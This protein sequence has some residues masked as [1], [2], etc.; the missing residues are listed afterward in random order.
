MGHRLSA[1][2]DRLREQIKIAFLYEKMEG[3]E[4]ERRADEITGE[5]FRK[6][7]EIQKMLLKDVQAGFDGDPAAKSKEAVIVSIRA[8]M[9]FMCTVWRTFFIWR[10]FLL[11]PGL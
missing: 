7:P 2:Y 4:A 11:Y 5:F 6:L 3:V 1:L 10:G 8:F 9:R